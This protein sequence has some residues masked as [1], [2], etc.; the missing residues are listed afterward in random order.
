MRFIFS[1]FILIN[2]G[3]KIPTMIPKK[4]TEIVSNPTDAM[5]LVDLFESSEIKSTY[6]DSLKI[7]KQKWVEGLRKMITEP[8][9]INPTSL[10]NFCGKAPLGVLISKENPVG[11]A[12]LMID[13]YDDGIGKYYNGIDSISL[14]LPKRMKEQMKLNISGISYSYDDDQVINPVFATFAYVLTDNYNWGWDK[15]YDVG[16]ENKVWAGSTLGVEKRVLDRFFGYNVQTFG[17][18]FLSNTINLDKVKEAV[19]NKNH[20]YLLVNS[21]LLHNLSKAGRWLIGTHYID[22]RK[23]DFGNKG[24]R[25]KVVWWEYGKLF[26]QTFETKVF[27]RFVAGGV[28]FKTGS[29]N[30]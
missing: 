29:T 14:I 20:V 16:D 3:C 26:E 28:V 15:K 10:T 17:S 30:Q 24:K 2:I 22:V 21:R 19:D 6:L 5:R 12:H 11:L 13:L 23:I 4:G 25:I 9:Q 27:K 18:N 7:S 1:F 8:E